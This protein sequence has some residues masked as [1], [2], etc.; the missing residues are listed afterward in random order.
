MTDIVMPVMDGQEMWTQLSADGC[1][2]PLIVM[3]GFPR[4]K[5][6]EDLLRSAAAFL[7]KPFG[8]REI[9]RAVRHTLD[10]TPHGHGRSSA[11]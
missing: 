9:T 5:H 4:S 10:S 8:P 7:Q 3:S 11:N 6:T 1:D 2:K